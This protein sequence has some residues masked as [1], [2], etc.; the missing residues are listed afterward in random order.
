MW[1]WCG[2]P[3]IAQQEV[4]AIQLCTERRKVSCQRRMQVD[5]ARFLS[6]G[7]G[8]GEDHVEV[9]IPCRTSLGKGQGTVQ[10]HSI[11]FVRQYLLETLQ[12]TLAESLDVLG[13]LLRPVQQI[14]SLP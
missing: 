1:R 7:Q 4:V 3:G 13:N 8:L 10:V 12:E 2:L 14:S 11:Q 6:A 9:D 5:Q